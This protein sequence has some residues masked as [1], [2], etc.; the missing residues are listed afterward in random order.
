MRADEVLIEMAFP[1]AVVE[2]KVR[3]KEEP[4]NLHLI[5]LLAFDVTDTTKVYWRKE[6]LAETQLLAGYSMRVG[7]RVRRLTAAEYFRM[8]YEE[9]F[10][11]NEE[12]Y[13][14]GLIR[15]AMTKAEQGG[16]PLRRNARPALDIASV[17]KHVQTRLSA[18]LTEGEDGSE[19]IETVGT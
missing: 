7:E 2:A 6:I 16:A 15:M 4:I 17:V 3:A 11:Q 12:P 14:Q 18:A 9:P 5:K 8:L 10:N 19:I 13:T 1:K